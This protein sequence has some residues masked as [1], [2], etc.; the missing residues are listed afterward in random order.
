MSKEKYD[1]SELAKNFANKSISFD[2]LEALREKVK[3]DK[4]TSKQF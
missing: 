1:Y 2:Q 4:A 3:N